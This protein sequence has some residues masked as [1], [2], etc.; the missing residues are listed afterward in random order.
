[1]APLPENAGVDFRVEDH[2][3]TFTR[4]AFLLETAE[5]DK[6]YYP[7]ASIEMKLALNQIP[8]ATVVV[9][10]QSF[11]N[12]E[13][14]DPR[15]GEFIFIAQPEPLDP[16]FIDFVNE[17][18][19]LQKTILA[20]GATA[21]LFV[22]VERSDGN[23]TQEI[24]IES[25]IPREA[26]I[27]S[28]EQSG[29]FLLSVT[30]MHPAYLAS[31]A[32]GWLPNSSAT[33]NPPES[34]VLSDEGLGSNIPDLF[35]GVNKIY[36]DK[37]REA[38]TGIVPEE[39]EGDGLSDIECA[40]SIEQLS[41]IAF[42]RLE[43]SLDSFVDYIEW[44]ALGGNDLPFEGE[45][46]PPSS[47]Q[48]EYFGRVLWQTAGRQ[49]SPW[50]TF[51]SMTGAFDM[52]VSGAPSDSKLLVTPFVPW[53]KWS[54]RLF[55]S[56]IYA[57]QMPGMGQRDVSG[58]LAAYNDGPENDFEN[59]YITALD[60]GSSVSNPSQLNTFGGY[61]CPLTEDPV[62]LGPIAYRDLPSWL[63]EYLYDQGGD[64]GPNGNSNPMGRNE[65]NFDSASAYDSD[66]AP[67]E[68]P[69]PGSG[70]APVE[71]SSLVNQWCQQAFFRLYKSD[72]AISIN[73][74]LL[75]TSPSANTPGGYVRPGIVVKVSSVTFPDGE[76]QS[77]GL[78]EE[79]PVLYF[80]V[81]SVTHQI[82]PGGRTATTTLTG[83]Y[84][85]FAEALDQAGIGLEQIEN[86]V[87]N[88]I[89]D[90]LGEY[91]ATTGEA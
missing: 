59:S 2:V 54:M 5:G 42:D 56:E 6:F 64:F 35:I 66:G 7:V 33:L 45:M 53:G 73:T 91:T 88:P 3:Y 51:V 76:I 29:S 23:E 65:A 63:R 69:T 41:D 4:V 87:A 30:L 55:D 90:S 28:T 8:T 26:A 36:A 62:L 43:S 57:N 13:A 38:I 72:D 40:T 89:F 83:A 60:N 71:Y 77:L 37:G 47:A 84:V 14:T 67:P 17:Y 46:V 68:A 74:R 58:V 16:T 79:E 9:A 52:V 48:D 61:V 10:P 15:D 31:S 24:V 49:D 20:E 81:T 80:Y 11:M 12:E 70:E 22:T 32:T 50:L 44:A 85:R 86:G 75:I 82:S 78:A 39:G 25:W 34:F 18:R 27:N 21:S 1:V 19:N